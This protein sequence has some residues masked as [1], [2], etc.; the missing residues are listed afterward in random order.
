MYTKE[1]GSFGWWRKSN[2]LEIWHIFNILEKGINYV[3]FIA[4]VV[5]KILM[6][7]KKDMLIL[8]SM[9]SYD[10]CIFPLSP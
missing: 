4:R 1:N 2:K 7:L 8:F 5:I 10:T 6:I 9:F 3:I